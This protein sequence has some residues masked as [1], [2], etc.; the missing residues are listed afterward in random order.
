MHNKSNTEYNDLIPDFL[1]E[2]GES[3]QIALSHGVKADH[4]ILDPGIGFAKTYDQNLIIMNHLEKIK[5]SFPEYPVLLGT[6]RKSMIGKAL[7]DVPTTERCEGTVA[8]TVVGI[9]KHCDFIRVHDIKENKDACVM[10]DAI[11]RRIEV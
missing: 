4:I 10:T 7:G 6:S 3:L 2:L 8:T 5:E 9:M 11:V 1:Q